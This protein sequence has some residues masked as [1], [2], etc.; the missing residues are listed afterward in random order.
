MKKQ[1]KDTI[2]VIIIKLVL[3]SAVPKVANSKYISK[4]IAVGIIK[5]NF[6]FANILSSNFLI[7]YHRFWC[8]IDIALRTDYIPSLRIGEKIKG[9]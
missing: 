3:S 5:D 2:G 8:I 6:L 7:N 9:L 1:I 4:A